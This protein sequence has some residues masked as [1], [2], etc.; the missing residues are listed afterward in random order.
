M[1]SILKTITPELNINCNETFNS[2]EN[3]EIRRKLVPELI[4]ALKPNHRVS[5]DQV[6]KWLQSLHK[7]R[8]SRNN[9]ETKGQL[10]QDDRRLHSNSRF[11]EV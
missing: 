9:Y 2:N 8:R 7:S 1:K 11:T 10:E 5:H 3:V 4:K 6:N